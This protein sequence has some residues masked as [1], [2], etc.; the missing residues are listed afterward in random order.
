MGSPA[1]CHV[2]DLSSRHADWL[3]WNPKIHLMAPMLLRKRRSPRVYFVMLG[4]D[5]I[6]ITTD[7]QTDTERQ[8]RGQTDKQTRIEKRQTPTDRNTNRDRQTD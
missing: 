5:D 7:G 1:Q 8:T 6:G 4:Q 3:L 2:M